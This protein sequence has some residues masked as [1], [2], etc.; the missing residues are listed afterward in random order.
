[1]SSLHSSTLAACLIVAAGMASADVTMSQSNDPSAEIEA[2]I[3]ADAARLLGQ[4]HAALAGVAPEM[5]AAMTAE[6]KVKRG[7]F[8][9]VARLGRDGAVE[10]LPSEA[11]VTDAGWLA[12]QPAPKGDDQFQCLATALYFE[13]RGEGVEGQVAVAEVILNRV[14]NAEYPSTICGVVNQASTQGCQFSY[15]CDGKSDAIGDRPAFDQAGR[16]ARAMMDGAPRR[17]TAGATHFHTPQVK[18]DW[19][20]RFTKTATIGDHIFYRQPGAAPVPVVSQVTPVAA[21]VT[22]SA[23]N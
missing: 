12:R 14:A 11:Q 13:A 20:R 1:M 23:R 15:V 9:P 19:S 21:M 10:R 6:P 4:E 16:I 17:L 3:E 5:V 8:G 22:A 2:G 18:P 7:L